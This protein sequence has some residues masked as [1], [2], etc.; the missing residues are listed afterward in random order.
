VFEDGYWSVRG[1]NKRDIDLR[2]GHETDAIKP[3]DDKSL[4]LRQ[5]LHLSVARKIVVVGV[6]W[7]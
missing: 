2:V 3:K 7:G 6:M 5:S 1:I 4:V